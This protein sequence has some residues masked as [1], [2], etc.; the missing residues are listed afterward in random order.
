MELMLL[1]VLSPVVQCQWGLSHS[2][3]AAITSVSKALT[4]TYCVQMH[5]IM[6]SETNELMSCYS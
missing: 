1:S 2:E 6:T 3:A 5:L 4:V